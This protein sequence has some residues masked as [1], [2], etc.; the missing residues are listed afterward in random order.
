MYF[1]RR[2]NP[3]HIFGKNTLPPERWDG[4]FNSHPR[5]QIFLEGHLDSVV[6]SLSAQLLLGYSWSFPWL[7]QWVGVKIGGGTPV[8]A[9]HFGVLIW[10]QHSSN[11]KAADL[12]FPLQPVRVLL[13][14][15]CHEAFGHAKWVLGSVLGS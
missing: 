8:E 10:V 5:L 9:I 2:R 15:A 13:L 7:Q 3:S 14:L 1:F 6:A 11:S 4:V 12:C